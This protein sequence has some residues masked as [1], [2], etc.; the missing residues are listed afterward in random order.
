[1]RLSRSNTSWGPAVP[2]WPLPR[3]DSLAVS[4]QQK[5]CSNR[6]LAVVIMVALF[7]IFYIQTL[8]LYLYNFFFELLLKPKSFVRKN[9]TQL[10]GDLFFVL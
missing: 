10:Q 8:T 3:R 5:A 4:E 9:V 6:K 2:P 1:M 7:I